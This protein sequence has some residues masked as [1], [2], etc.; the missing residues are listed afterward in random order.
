MSSASH[1]YIMLPV[2]PKLYESANELREAHVLT[3]NY[4]VKG[5]RL[6]RGG[7][8]NRSLAR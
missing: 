8:I 3:E 7:S 1:D 6:E 2:S 4:P 5:V